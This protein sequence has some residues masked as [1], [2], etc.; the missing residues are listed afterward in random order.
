M[1]FVVLEPGRMVS[2]PPAGTCAIGIM[3]KVPQRGRVKTRLVPPLSPD[4]ACA[5]A[6][7]FLRDV[8]ASIVA[9]GRA[10]PAIQGIAVYLPRGEE[11]A[12]AGVLPEGFWLLPQRGADL[13]ERLLHATGDLLAAGFGS[14]CLVNSDSPTLPERL[15]LDAAHALERPGDRVVLGPAADGGYYLVGLKRPHRRLFE[16]IAWSTPAVLAQT[17]ERAR[18]LDLEVHLLPE[19]YDVDD[20]ESLRVLCRE[21]FGSRDGIDGRG[22]STRALLDAILPRLDLR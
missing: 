6:G 18:E 12:L 10:H 21:L 19:W 17:L 7:C 20:G 13:G 4:E 5:L 8:A 16:D 3:A 14:A 2:T 22:A 1:R 11:H 9:A 15:L